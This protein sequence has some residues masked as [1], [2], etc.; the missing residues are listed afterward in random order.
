M[1][2]DVVSQMSSNWPAR[3]RVMNVNDTMLI[4]REELTTK[5]AANLVSNMNYRLKGA[6]I[7]KVMHDEKGDSLV[8]CIHKRRGVDLTSHRGR[9]LAKLTE[10]PMAAKPPMQP[11][12]HRNEPM[13]NLPAIAIVECRLLNNH[14][15]THRPTNDEDLNTLLTRCQQNAQITEIEIFRPAQKLSKQV[16]WTVAAQ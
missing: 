13:G 8:T 16:Q 3:L 5:Q 9:Q 14:V 7:Y 2:R 15:Q 12:T 1:T 10:A 11:S 4:A 6:A